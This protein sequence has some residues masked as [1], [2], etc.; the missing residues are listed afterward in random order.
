MKFIKNKQKLKEYEEYINK[1][2]K[3]CDIERIERTKLKNECNKIKQE[4]ENLKFKMDKN[5]LKIKK[6]QEQNKF[7]KQREKKLQTIEM[8][9]QNRKEFGIKEISKFVLED[10]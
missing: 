2:E 5:I 1:L 9:F 10:E 6:I 4:Y 3:D 8:M 7:L